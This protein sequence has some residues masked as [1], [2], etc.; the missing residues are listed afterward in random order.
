VAQF[1]DHDRSRVGLQD[2]GRRAAQA[3]GH[4]LIDAQRDYVAQVNRAALVVQHAT[5]TTI[6]SLVTC[7]LWANASATFS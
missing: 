5:S 7:T 3:L 2:D 4:P 6:R 1:A